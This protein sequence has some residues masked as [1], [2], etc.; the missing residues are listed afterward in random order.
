MEIELEAMPKY[1]KIRSNAY[2]T[3]VHLDTT[4]WPDIEDAKAYKAHL[5][6]C[7]DNP[8]VGFLARRKYITGKRMTFPDYAWR[9]KKIMENDRY[10]KATKDY[11]N[12]YV[13]TLYPKTKH[14]RE[15]IVNSDRIALDYIKPCK[16]YNF[17]DKMLIAMK[18]IF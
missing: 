14:I 4:M 15:Y 16:G 2:W 13:K 17:F 18:K 1:E 10:I 3:R 5:Q 6:D 12:G 7:I 8:T 11:L 9:N